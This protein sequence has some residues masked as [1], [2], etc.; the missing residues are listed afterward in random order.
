MK[1]SSRCQSLTT[2]DPVSTNPLRIATDD[3]GAVDGATLLPRTPSSLSSSSSE[4][5]ESS[6]SKK[7]SRTSNAERIQEMSKASCASS[8]VF[9]LRTV[10]KAF[11]FSSLR[12]RF[13]FL[14]VFVSVP[15]PTRPKK[16]P[17][18]TPL[19]L[20]FFR[21]SGDCDGNDATSLSE[22]E[23]C[24]P[25]NVLLLLLS[26][27]KWLVVFPWELLPLAL[28]VVLIL[29]CLFFFKSLRNRK[30]YARNTAGN[31]FSITSLISIVANPRFKAWDTFSENL[32]N[33][34]EY[35][36]VSPPSFNA[37]FLA[38]RT[39][40]GNTTMSILV[41]SSSFTHTFSMHSWHVVAIK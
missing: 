7:S 17:P 8:A 3:D 6:S 19:F 18:P 11:F 20:F 21:F 33:S 4:E 13:L 30:L 35:G 5:S 14:L 2:W 34:C 1:P 31:S 10:S 37:E 9:W 41:S 15:P 40:L 32:F 26:L 25:V 28:P 23:P 24:A 12:C 36:F 27:L 38:N 39:S 29:K 22:S 16:Y